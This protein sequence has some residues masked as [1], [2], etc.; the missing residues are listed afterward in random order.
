V[1]NKITLFD[2]TSRAPIVEPIAEIEA[3][4]DDSVTC[5]ANLATKDGLILY[6]GV[7]SSDEDR[8]KDNNEHF[9]AFE[10]QLPKGKVATDDADANISYLSKTKLFAP[11]QST[12]A[13]K[14]GYQRLIR[15]SPP[16]R[17]ATST[18]TRRIGAIASS[19]A[20]DENEVVVFNAISNK[21]RDPQDILQRIKLAKG[22]EANDFDIFDRGDGQFQLA[23]VLDYDVI[24]HNISQ[25]QSKS[26]NERRKLYSIPIP[27]LGKKGGR[28]KLRCIRWLT[29]EHLLLLVNKPNRTGVEMLIVH[30]YEEGPGSV[31]IRKTLPKRVK[32]ASDMDVALLD[33]DSTGAYQIAVAV[34]AIDISLLVYTIDYHGR[35]SNSLSQFHHFATYDNVHEVQMTKTVFS[36]FHKPVV[37]PDQSADR[38][39]G[40]QYLR[41]ASTSLGNTISVE[42]FEL[43]PYNSRYVL[44][45]ARTRNMYTAAT[46]LVIAMVV[47]ALALLIQSFIDPQGELTR[48]I[49]P[50]SLQNAGSQYKPMGEMV[51]EKRHGAILNNADS[52][53]VKTAHRI[54]DLLHLHMPHH[55]SP[56]ATAQ[57]KALVIHH[58]SEG[59]EL[60]TEV[61]EST[62]EVIRKHTEAKQWEELSEEERH[63]WRKKLSDAGMWAVGEGETILKS[64]FFG[65]IA[66]A[67]G[68]AA[69]GVIG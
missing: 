22:E 17:T 43:Q 66:G 46:Y 58:D 44:Q 20:G 34:A 19:L 59:S 50:R 5:L 11:V 48:H 52:P 41:L 1:K 62:D 55:T 10:V 68:A 21:P 45:T 49:V 24:V 67:I 63:Y 3:S 60:S 25:T 23:Y 6:A 14:E 65:N 12:N 13:K 2:F 35:S 18:P 28:S 64:I 69:Q 61:H 54:Q 53:V 15:L 37:P 56:D 33:P 8:I 42:S 31:I 16:Q 4:T 38:K 36:P 26:K 39:A 27:E 57:Q 32:A 7:N 9:R 30:M 47:A 51:R 29:P 40:P